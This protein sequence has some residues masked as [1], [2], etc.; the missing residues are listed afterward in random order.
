MGAPH[1]NVAFKLAKAVKKVL[2]AKE[3]KINNSIVK[4]KP[5]KLKKEKNVKPENIFKRTVHLKN[6]NSKTTEDDIREHFANCGNIENVKIIAKKNFTYGFIVFEKTEC[7]QPALKL[8]NSVLNNATIKVYER[9]IGKTNIEV[10]RDP[11]LTILLRNTQQLKCIEG[12]KLE[13]IFEKCGE[14]DLLDIM[15]KK[16]VLAFVTFKTKDAA[17]KAF[18]MDGQVVQG[19]ELAVEQY[20]T[21]KR[22]TSVFVAHLPHGML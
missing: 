15:C 7:V 6:L 12:K 13:K 20:S 17:E 10:K 18:K 22:K 3:I 4:V 14:V 5:Y 11:N 19:I 2:A 9:S 1:V 8:H 21:E 16:N